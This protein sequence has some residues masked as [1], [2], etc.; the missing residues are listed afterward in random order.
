[1]IELGVNSLNDPVQPNGNAGEATTLGADHDRWAVEWF[2]VEQPWREDDP[3]WGRGRGEFG[4]Q[5]IF[6]VSHLDPASDDIP[7]DVD[8]A[9]AAAESLKPLVVLH[10]VPRIYDCTQAYVDPPRP[11]TDDIYEQQTECDI[12]S[13][14]DKSRIEGL[15]EVLL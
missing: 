11:S 3:A 2:W 8:R 14:P 5:G 12:A 6:Y 9:A 1:L 4:W 10:G 7:F 13:D 15:F